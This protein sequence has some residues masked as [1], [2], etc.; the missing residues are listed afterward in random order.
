[1]AFSVTISMSL[2]YRD[3]A[4]WFNLAG[5]LVSISTGVYWVFVAQ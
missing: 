5:L 2:A 3:Y 4:L 1:M